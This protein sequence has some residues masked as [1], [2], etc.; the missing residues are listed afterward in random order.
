M[1]LL[2]AG[3]GGIEV[4]LRIAECSN[5]DLL[6]EEQLWQTEE[7]IPVSWRGRQSVS[8]TFKIA[9]D[10]QTGIFVGPDGVSMTYRIVTAT[11]RAH[12][13]FLESPARLALR[14]V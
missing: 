13:C 7:T 2:L 5:P 4:E 8:G 1:T 12:P 10:G 11:F 3:C 14:R 9:A 6:I